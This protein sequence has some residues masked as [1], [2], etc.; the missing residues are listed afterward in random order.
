LSRS[1]LERGLESAAFI[2]LG[3]AGAP[4]PGDRTRRRVLFAAPTPETEPELS[5][6]LNPFPDTLTVNP[7]T[8]QRGRSPEHAAA[9][10]LPAGFA[11]NLPI[12]FP[13]VRI[14]ALPCGT[15]FT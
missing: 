11:A 9:R 12:N 2:G 7:A 4:F 15:Y 5:D 8:G 1:F 6:G 14:P 13:R 10:A 3:A